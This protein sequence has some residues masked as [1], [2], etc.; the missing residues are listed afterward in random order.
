MKNEETQLEP[1]LLKGLVL[2][3]LVINYFNFRIENETERAMIGSEDFIT[4][5]AIR[6]VKSWKHKRS[7]SDVVVQYIVNNKIEEL[8]KQNETI[9]VGH[10]PNQKIIDAIGEELELVTSLLIDELYQLVKVVR[11]F[12]ISQNI[13]NSRSLVSLRSELS[14]LIT[15]VVKYDPV[16]FQCLIEE[17]LIVIE[18]LV[19]TLKKD[20]LLTSIHL[21]YSMKALNEFKEAMATAEVKECFYCEEKNLYEFLAIFTSEE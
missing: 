18:E 4:A 13:L 14:I 1:K 12:T 2:E 15:A 10:I 3:K 16:K 7:V 21:S 20:E 5:L 8:E 19:K 17:T 11:K 9:D 6:M